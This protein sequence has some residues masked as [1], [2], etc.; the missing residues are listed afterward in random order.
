MC[1]DLGLNISVIIFRLATSE[2]VQYFKFD[3]VGNMYVYA[4]GSGFSGPCV[5]V[6]PG[7]D[8]QEI[9]N[10]TQKLTQSQDKNVFEMGA[11]ASVVSS[12]ET[13]IVTNTPIKR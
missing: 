7:F 4:A 3:E 8:I 1:Y 2:D 11:V 10:V 9:T 6:K 12:T 13:E 5:E